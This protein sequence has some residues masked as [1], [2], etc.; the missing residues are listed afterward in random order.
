MPKP[1]ERLSAKQCPRLLTVAAW[2][3]FWFRSS[4][5]SLRNTMKTTIPILSLLVAS[6]ALAAADI[7]VRI[8]VKAVLNP[9]T[10]NRQSG[11]SDIPFSNTVVGM[12]AM[13]QSY[14]RGY[15]LQ[16]LG[17]A[18]INVGGLGQFNSG[19]SQYYSTDFVNDPDGDTL[20]DQFEANA[21]ADLGTY[22][23]DSTAVNIYIVQFAGANWNVCSFPGHQ[24][25]LV[26][27]AAG[28]SAATTVLHEIGHYFNLSHTFNGRQNL[29]SDNST[30]TNGCSCATFVGGGSDG[31]ADTILDHDCWTSQNDI[32]VGN[33]GTSYNSLSAGNQ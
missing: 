7:T 27:G 25:I 16:W 19:P 4:S 31:V 6:V 32:A 22:G 24:I 14:G 3:W 30:C 5:V 29:N 11:V 28:Y 23:W 10:G 20:K 33:F 17:N 26:N 2:C 15:Q 8:S 1:P 18:L 21:I 12:N 13:L 9:A